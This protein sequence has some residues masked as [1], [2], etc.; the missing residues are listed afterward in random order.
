MFE[1]GFVVVLG[2]VEVV[3]ESVGAV[4]ELG[5][6]LH[7]PVVVEGMLVHFLVVVVHSGVHSGVHSVV[8]VLVDCSTHSPLVPYSPL[9]VEPA[10]DGTQSVVVFELEQSV[11]YELVQMVLLHSAVAV[12]F[13]P[14]SA[15]SVVQPG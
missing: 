14:H 15:V 11:A 3:R 4:L 9:V 8:L 13:E 10:E 7:G 12:H 6:V 5:V 1:L 2:V